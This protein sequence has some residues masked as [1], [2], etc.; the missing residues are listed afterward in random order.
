MAAVVAFRRTERGFVRE[1]YGGLEAT[2]ALP[3]IRAELLLAV[4]Y[5]A[6]DFVPEPE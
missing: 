2:V 3:E 6:V 4:I 5:D 1:A